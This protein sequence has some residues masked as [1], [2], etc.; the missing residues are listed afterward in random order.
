MIFYVVVFHPYLQKKVEKYWPDINEKITFGNIS[1]KYISSEVFANFEYRK[2]TIYCEETERQ[3]LFTNT[4]FIAMYLT[5]YRKYL[6]VG[7]N[8]LHHLA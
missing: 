8:T 2:F 5:F 3:V 6:L 4:F 1:V 7:A